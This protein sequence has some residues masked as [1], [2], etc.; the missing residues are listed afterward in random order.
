[1]EKFLI[2][3]IRQHCHLCE[4]EHIEEPVAKVEILV[5]SDMV[6]A[7]MDLAQSQMWHL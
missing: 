3:I 1:M 2:L 4:I 6:G 5:P 7:V